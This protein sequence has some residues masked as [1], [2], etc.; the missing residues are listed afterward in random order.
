MGQGYDYRT[1]RMVYERIN[2]FDAKLVKDPRSFAC[3]ISKG[4]QDLCLHFTDA[5]VGSISEKFF[6]FNLYYQNIIKIVIR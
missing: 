6:F 3:K 1:H 4:S 5:E 2:M